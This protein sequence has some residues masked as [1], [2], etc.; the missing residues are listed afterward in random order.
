[1]PKIATMIGFAA[2]LLL[3]GCTTQRT[4]FLPP[5][6]SDTSPATASYELEADGIAAHEA[7]L[8]AVSVTGLHA[9]SSGSLALHGRAV[10]LNGAERYDVPQVGEYPP[11]SYQIGRYA[12]VPLYAPPAVL[13][14][15]HGARVIVQP[16]DTL[17]G[18]LRRYYGY[19]DNALLAR[20]MAINP[21]IN[22]N[23]I[24]P[25]QSVLLP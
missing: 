9:L 11:G 1:M 2:T 8:H 13:G 21:A 10:G 22:P 25:G 7:R 15:P 20:A 5:D 24:V 19:V 6:T 14:A 23:R 18:L 4:V 16:G 17:S 3:V 12:E